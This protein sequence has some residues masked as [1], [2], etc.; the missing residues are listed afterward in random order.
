MEERTSAQLTP[1]NNSA[2]QVTGTSP[3]IPFQS[4]LN[5]LPN[6]GS[7][8]FEDTSIT[9]NSLERTLDRFGNPHERVTDPLEVILK[10]FPQLDAYFLAETL[11]YYH[12]NFYLAV[13]SLVGYRSN[14]KHPN[15][16]SSG[17]KDPF[18]QNINLGI[19]TS[20]NHPV[21]ESPL[22]GRKLLRRYHNHPKDHYNPDHQRY[23]FSPP[24]CNTA[25]KKLRRPVALISKLDTHPNN[26]RFLINLNSPLAY[27]DDQ[28]ST[29]SG[30]R[31]P[32]VRGLRSSRRHSEQGS[33]TDVCI[34]QR[35]RVL[36]TASNDETYQQL[37][38]TD[39]YLGQLTIPND[40]HDPKEYKCKK[41]DCSCRDRIINDSDFNNNNNILYN[42]GKTNNNNIISSDNNTK[43]N[44]NND[45]RENGR[46]CTSYKLLETR[47]RTLDAVMKMTSSIYEHQGGEKGGEY[48]ASVKMRDAHADYLTYLK[49][50]KELKKI[51][52]VTGGGGVIT[53]SSPTSSL[54]TSAFV[55]GGGSGKKSVSV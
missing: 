15:T 7:I 19:P 42:N 13:E 36:L 25:A 28:T 27:K 18:F 3:N 17:I 38:P 16:L 33:P 31:P 11:H 29:F 24:I 10:I 41:D 44:N 35:Q 55:F 2:E 48:D 14:M 30:F 54:M 12:G 6:R 9:G 50:V 22:L 20:S 4:S 34:G 53:S 52:R 5:T 51:E 21:S 40:M 45:T 37:S 23:R 43:E 47:K 46:H 49:S 1:D 8:A 39:V 26:K 32:L